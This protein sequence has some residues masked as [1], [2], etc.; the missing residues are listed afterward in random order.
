MG[1][2]LFLERFLW[3]DAR[4]RAGRYPNARHLAEHFELAHKSAQ[5]HIEFFRDRL[6]APLVYDHKHRGYCYRDPDFQLPVARLNEQDTLALLVGTR[7]ITDLAGPQIGPRL[8]DIVKKLK[9]AL[10]VTLPGRIPPERAFSLLLHGYYHCLPQ[11]FAAISDAVIRC[12]LLRLSYRAP[13]TPNATS[14]T[15]EP[16][17]LVN[18]GGTWYLIAYCRKRHDWR[19]FNLARID[20]CDRLDESFSPRDEAE[21]RPLLTASFG[22]FDG[23][24][25]TDVVLKFS[26]E[27]SR[28]VRGRVYH[29]GQRIREEPDGSIVLTLPVS[30]HFEIL[31]EILG[32]GAEVEVLAP[33]WMRRRVREE[34]AAMAK[35]YG[36]L[37]HE[38]G[39]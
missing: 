12:Q 35:K 33:E 10:A 20:T 25:A 27:R 24:D 38:L 31:M 8:E 32:H 26:P 34:I 3:F 16:H 36:V 28:W 21:W 17:H 39:E 30:H 4:V 2:Q 19:I 5:R 22:I 23:K 29:P 14:R 37:G 1:E 9:V 18:Y 6:L 7:L 11:H 13:S 15:V